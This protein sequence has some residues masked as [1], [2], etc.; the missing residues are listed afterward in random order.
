MG[1]QGRTEI[2][3]K[4]IKSVGAAESVGTPEIVS[5]GEAA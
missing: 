1:M 2:S 4:V 5:K 3:V